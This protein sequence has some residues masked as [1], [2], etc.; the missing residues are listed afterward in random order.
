MD[1][2]GAI[3]SPFVARVVLAARHKGI[4]HKLLMPKDGV[5]G[6]AFL[7]LNPM[8]KM[9][10][11][12]DGSTV[13]FESGVILDYLDAKYKSK[14]II[15][16]AAKA[17]AQARLIG[18]VFAEYV[19]APIFGL[20]SH[21]DPTKRDQAVVDQKL[22]DLN[23]G[24]D[25]AEK[26]LVAKPFAA[27]PKFSIADCYAIPTLFYLHM[28][29]PAFNFSPLGGRKKLAR[30]M[31]RVRKEKLTSQFLDEMAAALKAWTPP[32]KA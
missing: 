9:P 11:I 10:A 14:R 7:K 15:P 28:I 16:S 30:Y 19:H 2:Y 8:G 3:L 12:K 5:K 22:A 17:G 31:A 18:A 27:G 29:A 4:K 23:R 20:F 21:R 1:I 24:L 6:A 26:L 25:T 32:A 13:L